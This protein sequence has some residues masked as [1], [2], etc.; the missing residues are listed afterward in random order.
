ME[1]FNCGIC[2]H[3][4]V[5]VLVQALC[6]RH[7]W[8]SKDGITSTDP[9]LQSLWQDSCWYDACNL[10]DAMCFMCMPFW[11]AV[12]APGFQNTLV[13]GVPALQAFTRNIDHAEWLTACAWLQIPCSRQQGLAQQARKANQTEL[14]GHCALQRLCCLINFDTLALLRQHSD[15]TVICIKK[16]SESATIPKVV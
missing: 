9:G 6:L 4:H 8:R 13:A 15:V 3:V 10:D 11:C 14:W 5:H 7:M 12:C 16:M 2:S 1:I